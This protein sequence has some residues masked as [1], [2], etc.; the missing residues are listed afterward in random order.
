MNGKL[1][2]FE[3]NDGSGKST[4]ILRAER[5]L[6]QKG[7]KVLV[8]KEP[9]GTEIGFRI[10]KLLLDPA[11]KMDALTEAFLLA[12]D[13]NEHV[14]NVLMPALDEGYIILSDR[15]ILSSIVY[16][17][18]VRG[19]GEE[20]IAKLNSVF[21]EK[22]KPDLYIVLTLHPRIATQRIKLA[23]KNDR[24]DIEDFDFHMKVYNAFKIVSKT[25]QRCINIETEGSIDEI[26]DK[27]R[28]ILDGFLDHSK[29]L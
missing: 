21:E 2:V 29:N 8:T 22:I 3:G 7:Y 23:A 25:Y 4:Q 28:Q 18:I 5:Y 24:L 16:Q 12:A 20:K 9:G 17:G 6:K 15:Y 27:I 11:Y 26:F 19:V 1:I 14:K 10:R 13:R